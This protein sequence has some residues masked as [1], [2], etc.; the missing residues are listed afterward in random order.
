MDCVDCSYHYHDGFCMWKAI[1]TD[2]SC[3]MYTNEELEISYERLLFLCEQYIKL[4]KLLKRKEEMTI[5]YPM[6]ELDN[7]YEE[8]LKYCVNDLHRELSL[9]KIKK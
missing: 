6:L 3:D 7:T 2:E 8:L 5:K 9:Y 4:Y 1:Y